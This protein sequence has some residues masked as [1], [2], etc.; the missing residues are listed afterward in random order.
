MTEP[1]TIDQLALA[2]SLRSAV[3]DV[4][5]RVRA[6]LEAL[7]RI[8]SCAFAGFPRE[9]VREAAAETARILESSGLACSLLDVTGGEPAVVGRA[10]REG[11]PRVL[12]YAHYDVQPE[13]D[14]EEWHSPPY[15]P[16]ERDGRLYGRGAA[17]DKSGIVMHAGA[18][19]AIRAVLGELPVDVTVL[20]EGEEEC[21]G[22]LADFVLEHPEVVQADAVVIADV[23]N[24]SLGQPTLVTA[25]RGLVDC[26][27]DVRTLPGPAHSGMYGGPAPDALL[28]LIRILDSLRDASGDT[29]ILPGFAWTGEPVAE[30]EYRA[31]LGLRPDQP[32]LGTGPLADRLITRP[33]AS[34]IGID[35]PR[36]EGAI[37]AVIPHARAK[38]SL[39]IPPGVEPAEAM[40]ALVAHLRDAAPWGVDVAVT[41]GDRGRGALIPTGGPAY[42]AARWALETSFGRPVGEAGEGGSIPLVASIMQAAPQAEVLLMGAE[43]PGALIHA[44]NESVDL[45]ELE[46]MVFAEALFL[47]RLGGRAQ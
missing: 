29:V 11:A 2:E 39:R 17:D 46:S 41:P 26:V 42:A 9:P 20:I 35:A 33:S 23:G 34:V 25:L 27:V 16:T 15:E 8:P 21:S 4:M 37:N 14:V 30:A 40:A 1:T 43:D 13:G 47:A 36:V 5:P 31:E 19:A 22:P 45:A 7:V 44:P 12:L 32:L 28:A 3:R 38:V 6:D 18:L 24:R 10:P